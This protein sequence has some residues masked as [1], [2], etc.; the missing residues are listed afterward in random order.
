M[1]PDVRRYLQIRSSG[2]ASVTADGRRLL[3]VADL[4]GLAKAW[5]LPA[6]GGWPRQV[7]AGDER[8]QWVRTSPHDADVAV[9]GTDRDGDERTQLR[10]VSVT[11]VEEQPLTDDCA[12]IHRLGG[13]TPDGA[14]MV[15]AANDRNGVD[16]DLYRR[17][18][19]GGSPRCV[20]HLHGSQ[21]PGDVTPDGRHVL[22]VSPRSP[23][24]TDLAL[25]ALGDG[26][27]R[28]LV[29]GGRHRPG[30]FGEDGRQLFVASDAGRQLLAAA[31]IDL[32]SG[33]WTRF[34]PVD[35]DVDEVAVRAGVGAY[36]VNDAGRSRLYW[37]DPDTLQTTGQ[38]DLPVGVVSD[39]CVAPD[40]SWLTFSFDAAAH[41]RAVWRAEAG[42]STARVLTA[43]STMG[44]D[45]DSF[46][47]PTVE[48]VVSF[49]GLRVPVLTYRPQ[50]VSR[51]PVVVSVH[52]GP[53]AQERPA[54]NPV[55]Q[56][57]LARGVAVVAP[58]VRGSTGYGR[59]YT[60]LDDRHRRPDAIADLDAVARWASERFPAAPLAIM[61]ASYGGFMT[62][63][64]L[65]SFP[66]RFAAGVCIVGMANLVTFLE[67]T[68]D[69]RRALREAEYGY[70]A[71]DRELLATLSPLSHVERIR[72]PLLVIHGANDPRVP[73]GEAEQIVDHLRRRGQPVDYLRFDDEGHGIARFDN[74]VTAYSAVA[75]FLERHLR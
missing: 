66:E 24:D 58:N 57:L 71:S 70:L 13:F 65:T 18:L 10:R 33:T 19:D 68:G 36:T 12:T 54:F 42:A 64:A 40:G 75:D 26:V 22:V 41:P 39:L 28:T 47:T 14:A 55:Y 30:G 21:Q 51:P 38:V 11:G 46:V 3:L 37:F 67:H 74:R 62:L 29:A 48:H 6:P 49:D 1:V 32:T 2:G 43:S 44:I 61:G 60:S 45:P 50:G 15:Y 23:M 5:S 20:A 16:F 25:V 53:E 56:Y 63:A 9:V 4:D 69:Y 72:A 35:H 34:G 52:G 17:T 59:H 7:A 31:R 27:V 73:V 8:V